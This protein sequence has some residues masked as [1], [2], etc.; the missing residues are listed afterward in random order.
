MKL[1]DLLTK[2]NEHIK[3]MTGMTASSWIAFRSSGS[4][5]FD[6]RN[7]TDEKKD[8]IVPLESGD[9]EVVSDKTRASLI[10][11]CDLFVA[12]KLVH[13]RTAA[14]AAEKAERD[15]LLI[16][17]LHHQLARERERCARWRDRHTS[18]GKALVACCMLLAAALVAMIWVRL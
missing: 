15:Q 14:V 16:D 2:I 8:K 7:F 4:V 9:I 18:L 1:E 6:F 13:D 5:K 17:D 11:V 12:K 3:E 10:K